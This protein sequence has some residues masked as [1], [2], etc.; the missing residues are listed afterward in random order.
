MCLVRPL[1]SRAKKGQSRKERRE[2]E[3]PWDERIKQL[4]GPED[5]PDGHCSLYVLTKEE[6]EELDLLYQ[7]QRD[8]LVASKEGRNES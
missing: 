4:E 8:Y 1:P 2:M 6:A 7:K 3:T 5:Y